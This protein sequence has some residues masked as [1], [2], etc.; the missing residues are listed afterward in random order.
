MIPINST[1]QIVQ[2]VVVVFD[3]KFRCSYNSNFKGSF[4]FSVV[5]CNVVILCYS[6]N[7]SVL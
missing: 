7:P 3:P 6:C 5:F 1:L 4:L 2:L